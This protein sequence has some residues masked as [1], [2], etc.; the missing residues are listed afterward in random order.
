MNANDAVL[1][2]FIEDNWTEI[3]TAA[4]GKLYFDPTLDSNGYLMRCPFAVI[5]FDGIVL[6]N[7]RCALEW[8]IDHDAYD[9][10]CNDPMLNGFDA[11]PVKVVSG[12]PAGLANAF[13]QAC[14]DNGDDCDAVMAGMMQDYVNGCQEKPNNK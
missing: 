3:Y 12:V 14:L 4:D 8:L 1:L 9:H 11:L 7:V 5:D 6:L 13:K 10:V 2:S